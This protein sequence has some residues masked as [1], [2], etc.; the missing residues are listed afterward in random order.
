MTRCCRALGIRSATGADRRN[1]LFRRH[2][3]QRDR[4]GTG[5][6]AK[7][8]PDWDALPA[9][10]PGKAADLLRRCM[11]KDPH[12][13]LRDIGDAALEIAEADAESVGE[14]AVR[15]GRS[16][17]SRSL[18]MPLLFGAALIG[19]AAGLLILWKTKPAFLGE[20]LTK[21]A[22]QSPPAIARRVSIRLPEEWPLAP[23]GSAPAGVGRPALAIS[24]DGLHLAYAGE[25]DN[26]T[27][28]YKRRLDSMKVESMPGTSGTYNPFFSPDG[29]W[30]GFFVGNQLKK[31][32]TDGGQPIL[33]CEAINCYG[34]TWADAGKIY[35]APHEA[36]RLCSVSAEVGAVE[37][38]AVPEKSKGIAGFWWPHALPGGKGVLFRNGLLSL[39]TKKIQRLFQ[40][41]EPI[42]CTGSTIPIERTHRVLGR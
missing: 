9:S 25:H 2:D 39:P 22:G 20:M 24:P 1:A 16:G 32:S 38:V 36:S 6:F 5:Y 30:I 26:E 12:E 40:G 35:F 37:T 29:K 11:K 15:P 41:R 8:E 17:I 19:A 13:R 3:R 4:D 42:L 10:V 34:G 31:I 23:V 28:L 33:L 7:D 21:S 14:T 18:M 27:Q